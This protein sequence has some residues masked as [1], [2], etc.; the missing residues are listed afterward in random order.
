[1]PR[2][3]P[4]YNQAT[5]LLEVKYSIELIEKIRFISVVFFSE[6]EM[7]KLSIEITVVLWS[8]EQISFTFHSVMH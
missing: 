2:N 4:A 7:A 5:A 8:D 3:H 1:M 6:Y